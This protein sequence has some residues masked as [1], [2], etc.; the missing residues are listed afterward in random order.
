MS[1]ISSVLRALLE[2]GVFVEFD[3][4]EIPHIRGVPVLSGAF[5]VEK[6]GAPLAPA[7]R[8]LRLII[9][10]IPTNGGQWPIHGDIQKMPI[11]G[12][13]RHIA[14]QEGE[15]LLWS[16]EDIKG[17]FHI[18]KLPLAWQRW[19]VL[20]KPI[21]DSALGRNGPP[22]WLAVGVT[23]MGWLSAV[24]VVQHLHRRLYFPGLRNSACLR[25]AAEHRR[26]TGFPMRLHP[27]SRKCWKIYVDNWDFGEVVD[28]ATA[29]RILGE[30]SVEQLA[31]RE[32]C[33]L[34]NVPLAP[35]KSV[36][37]AFAFCPHHGLYGRWGEGGRF[38]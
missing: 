26:D 20:S 21:C 6:S 35:D 33:S 14:L 23:P 12:E 24:G 22:V 19:M 16:S 2:H 18:F 28:E 10:A 3:P 13:W 34:W 1:G 8:V 30:A 29:K 9:N 36:T 7:T 32:A 15:L 38:A 37:Y 5:G 27:Q 11:G 25:E 17:C 31:V 4:S